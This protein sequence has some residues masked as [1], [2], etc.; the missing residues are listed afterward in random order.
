MFNLM[1]NR[2]LAAFITFHMILFV[3]SPAMGALVPSQSSSPMD[4]REIQKDMDTIQRALETKQVQEKLKDYGLTPEEVSSRLSTMTPE[5][6]HML[7]TASDDVLAGG[8]S[9]LGTVI[10]ILVI[11]ILIV[12]ILKLSNK[13]VIIKMT[14]NDDIHCLTVPAPC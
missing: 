13:Q 11:I 3:T 4:A 5:Q 9:F 8:D 10:A 14:G 2:F 12:V 6:I 7:A 1:R